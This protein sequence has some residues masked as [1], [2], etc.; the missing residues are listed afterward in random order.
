VD[1]VYVTSSKA[2]GANNYGEVDV[3]EV[4]SESGRMRQ[5]PTSPFPSGGRDPVAE[6]LSTDSKNLYV[7][8]EDDNSIVQFAIG[9]DGKIY[10]QNTVNTPGIFPIA[11]ASEGS[12][13]FVADTYQPLPI[14]SP[15][16]PCSGS[17]A[18][19]P[20]SSTG[21]PG[22]AVNNISAGTNYWPLAAPCSA[23]NV[24]TPSSINVAAQ[25]KYLFVAAFDTTAAAA[26]TALPVVANP[27][28]LSG[29][30][31]APTGYVFAFTV[32]S[33][34]ALSAVSGSPF[35]VAAH[36]S[37]GAGVQPSAIASDPTGDHV[38]VTDMNGGQ[39]FGY[40]VSSGGL[41]QLSG[42]PFAAGNGPAAITVDPSG[43]NAY[44][45]NSLDNTITAYSIDSGVLKSFGTYP[46]SQ[47]PVAMLVDPATGNFVYAAGYL[48]GSISGFQ[49]KSGGAPSLVVA[50]QSP[51]PSNA[52]PTAMV[53]ITHGGTTAK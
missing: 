37:N 30:G 50:Q 31:T 13:L 4:N 14:C 20:L 26:N 40:A 19:L 15:E 9:N 12:L 8:N 45:A 41:S 2:A 34:G 48:S 47:Q 5:I 23:A 49:L 11:V 22:T 52:Q 21:T 33:G 16:E 6:A 17:V 29:A 44:A 51:F 18:V 36:G 38:Y 24:L 25:G 53:A 32:G 43:N 42:S 39:V 3:F 46:V 35:V 10:P 27:C 28:D 7:A 1:F